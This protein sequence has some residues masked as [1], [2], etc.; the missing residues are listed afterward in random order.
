MGGDWSTANPARRRPSKGRPRNVLFQVYFGNG[1]S[2]DGLDVVTDGCPNVCQRLELARLLPHPSGDGENNVRLRCGRHPAT[3][4]EHSEVATGPST[5]PQG[6]LASTPTRFG[7][8][9]VRLCFEGVS[10]GS[11]GTAEASIGVVFAD[12]ACIERD[13]GYTATNRS[14]STTTGSPIP[15]PLKGATAKCPPTI[16]APPNGPPSLR[17]TAASARCRDTPERRS[18]PDHDH[19]GADP[20]LRFPRAHGRGFRRRRQRRRL[21]GRAPRQLRLSQGGPPASRL[22]RHAERGGP[23]RR[24][25]LASKAGPIWRGPQLRTRS[26]T[27]LGS[28]FVLVSGFLGT[29]GNDDDPAGTSLQRQLRNYVVLLTFDVSSGGFFVLTWSL[30]LFVGGEF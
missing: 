23:C 13:F 7:G 6:S 4:S 10:A 16:S 3:C 24:R 1:P 18:A 27:N 2:D 15:T 9:D 11:T 8:C 30:R 5:S 26:H 28:F 21:H 20:G 25:G 19:S 12:P 17:A 22:R 29:S 14:T